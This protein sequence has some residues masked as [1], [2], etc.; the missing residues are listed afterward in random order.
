MV[1]SFA[2]GVLVGHQYLSSFSDDTTDFDEARVAQITRGRT[3]AKHVIELFGRPGGEF[4]HPLAK[5]QDGR[6]YVYNYSL[7][8]ADAASGKLTTRVKTLIVNFDPAGIVSDVD[9]SMSGK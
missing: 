8:Q 9:L 3:T 5:T 6:A 2:D 7:T 4:I 1:F